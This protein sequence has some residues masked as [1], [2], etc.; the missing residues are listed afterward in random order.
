MKRIGVFCGSGTG[1]RAIYREAAHFL[2]RAFDQRGIGLVYGGGNVGLVGVVADAVIE[3]GGAKSS[4]GLSLAC[5][6][7]RV[8]F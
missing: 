2:G 4:R 6:E 3:G 5:M 1:S 8:R 7:N